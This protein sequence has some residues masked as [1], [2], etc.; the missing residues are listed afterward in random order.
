MWYFVAGAAL[1]VII[2]VVRHPGI[3]QGGEPHP[4]QG[5]LATVAIGASTWL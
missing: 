3:L 4:V 2:T 1:N 5:M